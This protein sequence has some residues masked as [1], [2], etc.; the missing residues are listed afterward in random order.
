MVKN[1]DKKEFINKLLEIPKYYLYNDLYGTNETSLYA[2][3]SEVMQN[4]DLLFE[5]SIFEHVIKININLIGC[6]FFSEYSIFWFKKDPNLLYETLENAKLTNQEIDFDLT[7]FYEIQDIQELKSFL[8]YTSKINKIGFK[9]TNS[10]I[11]ACLKI[12]NKYIYHLSRNNL[13]SLF[14]NFFEKEN[15][16][17]TYIENVYTYAKLFP[18]FD[19]Y[20]TKFK[21][22][23]ES[24]LD[25]NSKNLLLFLSPYKN[26]PLLKNNSIKGRW[27]IIKEYLNNEDSYLWMYFEDIISNL[28]NQEDNKWDIEL[29]DLIS[30]I[31]FIYKKKDKYNYVNNIIDNVFIY[32][33][34]LLKQ[35]YK[36][37]KEGSGF[38]IDCNILNENILFNNIIWSII[39]E[40]EKSFNLVIRI[41]NEYY[42]V[43]INEYIP[44]SEDSSLYKMIRKEPEYYL[45]QFLF[46]KCNNDFTYIKNN[47]ITSKFIVE[48]IISI[49]NIRDIYQLEEGYD[50]KIKYIELLKYHLN[51]LDD[52]LLLDIIK[53]FPEV[54]CLLKDYKK[55]N[56]KLKKFIIENKLSI[57]IDKFD[58]SVLINIGLFFIVLLFIF[59][60]YR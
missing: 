35:I 33:H 18:L 31:D 55:N 10:E 2:N 38:S 26:I 48:R 28:L 24:Q 34:S 19:K 46:N 53:Q 8:Y 58:Y 1:M 47:N 9:L 14:K 43:N 16:K 36:I 3:Y 60:Y 45:N 39:L 30:E 52:I 17:I 27:N 11:L 59:F 29:I 44:L 32:S 37:I 54:Y 50:S 13:I 6:C 56:K 51:Q 49:F 40:N 41:C 20:S 57:F 4:L 5:K 22:H 23:Y 42:R 12:N 21:E 25:I 7:D 15:T